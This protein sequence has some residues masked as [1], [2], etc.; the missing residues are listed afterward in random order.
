M[1]DPLSILLFFA[2]FELL[3]GAAVGIGLRSLLKHNLAGGFFLIWGAG[4]GGI[5]LFIGAVMFLS[6]E[7][8]VYF[9]AQA[10]I[11][12]AAALAA[13]FLPDDILQPG[14]N[15]NGAY[16][17]AITGAIMAMVG[18]TVVILNLREGF[19]IGLVIGG[20]IGLLG[21]LILAGTLLRALRTT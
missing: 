4:F 20:I 2:V 10:F 17:G 21:A 9:Y 16:G 13:F 12:T 5:P 18:G 3:G 6:S 8:P 19:G 14:P 1:E 11:F 7:H 15:G